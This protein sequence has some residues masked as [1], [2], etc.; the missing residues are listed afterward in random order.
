MITKQPIDPERSG[1]EE[2][3]RRE[4]LNLPGGGNRIDFISCLRMGEGQE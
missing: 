1:I 2:G 3:A 4:H